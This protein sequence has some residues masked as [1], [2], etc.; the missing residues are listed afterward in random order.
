MIDGHCIP[1]TRNLSTSSSS[2]LCSPLQSPFASAPRSTSFDA[3][4]TCLGFSPSSRHHS[5]AATFHAGSHACATFRP[6]VFSTARRLTPRPSLQAYS[7]P[8]PRPGSLPFRGI[9]STRSHLFLIGRCAPAVGPNRA[10]RLSPAAARSGPRL[11]G[12]YPREAAFTVAPLFTETRA[13]PLIGFISSRPASPAVDRSLPAMLRS[14][15][16]PRAPSLSRSYP[17][18]VP[19]VSPAENLTDTSPFRLPARVFE[20]SLRTLRATSLQRHQPGC[21]RDGSGAARSNRKL[22]LYLSR[23]SSSTAVARDDL[24]PTATRRAVSHAPRCADD[25]SGAVSRLRISSLDASDLR[26]PVDQTMSSTCGL[27]RSPARSAVLPRTARM[28]AHP[29]PAALPASSA[30]P[31]SRKRR[32]RSAMSP[33]EITHAW[34]GTATR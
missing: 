20:P 30:R 19:S 9:L 5:S 34:T 32:A 31:V 7:I 21:P 24:P 29:N 13:A 27:E 16:L 17:A 4:F 2:S 18:L 28:V 6:P 15:R 12:L 26:L 22:P 25:L 3:S 11:R 1:F 23:R 33:R 14:R 10:H 8:Q